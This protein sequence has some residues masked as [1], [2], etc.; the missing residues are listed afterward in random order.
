MDIWHWFMVIKVLVWVGLIRRRNGW[1]GYWLCW[2]CF[3]SF[4]MHS[5][6]IMPMKRVG[7]QLCGRHCHW[8]G[9]D[10]NERLTLKQ[11]SKPIN[12]MMKQL[13]KNK[14]LNNNKSYLHNKMTF[15]FPYKQV[16]NN[17]LQLNKNNKKK[18]NNKYYCDHYISFIN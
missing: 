8:Y 9:T 7:W 13:L 2:S 15:I 3:G 14:H 5:R 10:R 18:N 1:L 4:C 11:R 6:C 12:N 16:I 17:N